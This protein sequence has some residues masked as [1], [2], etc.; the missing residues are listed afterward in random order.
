VEDNIATEE[1]EKT[2]DKVDDP[3]SLGWM[4][5]LPEKDKGGGEAET[6]PGPRTR[7]L[8]KD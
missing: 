5:T 7:S 1:G 4:G 2:E 8:K 6:V 3:V